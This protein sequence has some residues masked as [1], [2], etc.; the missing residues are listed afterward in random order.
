MNYYFT[1]CCMGMFSPP[2]FFN[3]GDVLTFDCKWK[4]VA[5]STSNSNKKKGCC[6]SVKK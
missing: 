4:I 1:Q 3:E 2:C 6:E 5:E